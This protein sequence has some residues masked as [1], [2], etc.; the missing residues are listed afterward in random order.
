VP[1]EVKR[2]K[3]SPYRI[4]IHFADNDDKDDNNY[5]DL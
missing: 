3:F 1:L 2:G 4:P 5:N